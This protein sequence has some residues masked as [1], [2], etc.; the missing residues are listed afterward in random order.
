MDVLFQL[1]HP[2]FPSALYLQTL[3]VPISSLLRAWVKWEKRLNNLT[4]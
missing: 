3:I 4:K 2:T 1:T